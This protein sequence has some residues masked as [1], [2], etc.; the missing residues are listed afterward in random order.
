[1]P[2]HGLAVEVDVEPGPVRPVE[3]DAGHAGDA[4]EAPYD[5]GLD[6]VR[7]ILGA[8]RDRDGRPEDRLVVGIVLVD[9]PAPEI[10]RQLRADALQPI[11]EPVVGALHVGALVELQAEVG[12]VPARPR[13]HRR[14]ARQR[15]QDVLHWLHD[16]ALDLLGRRVVVRHPHPEVRVVVAPGHELHGDAAVG[17]RAQDEGRGEQHRRRHRPTQ[18]ERGEERAGPHR[19]SPRRS[20]EMAR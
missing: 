13:P 4:L 1:M 20:A 6:G 7:R 11:D 10:V 14:D 15:L 5:L 3:L 9:E 2:V 17:D 8:L 19:S 12:V 16:G 18:R